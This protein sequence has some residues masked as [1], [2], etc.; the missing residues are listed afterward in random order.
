VREAAETALPVNSNRTPIRID[1]S[2]R[3][4]MTSKPRTSAHAAGSP[5][6]PL[7]PVANAGLIALDTRAIVAMGPIACAVVSPVC[8]LSGSARG[9]ESTSS[10]LFESGA[11]SERTATGE[12]YE[13]MSGKGRLG[14]VL[15]SRAGE[16]EDSP[17]SK[18]EVHEKNQFFLCD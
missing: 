16:Y 17:A 14:P 8:K 9:R 3:L 2:F 7:T 13:K 12:R 18:I 5:M 10:L 4:A 6:L 11:V 15:Q 1:R